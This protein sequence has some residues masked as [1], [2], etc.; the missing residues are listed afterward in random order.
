MSEPVVETVEVNPPAQQ[1]EGISEEELEGIVGRVVDSRLV[2]LQESINAIQPLDVDTLRSGIL[3]DITSALSGHSGSTI[4]EGKLAQTIGRLLD[5]KL[6]GIGSGN[7]TRRAGPISR[8]L[9]L[10]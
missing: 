8:W 7:V 5:D 1:S 4:D 6:K 2:P 10:V 9:G 3:E